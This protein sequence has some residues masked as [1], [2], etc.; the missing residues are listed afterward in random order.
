MLA[1]AV[2]IYNTYPGKPRPVWSGHPSGPHCP[3]PE[4]GK[5]IFHGGFQ[6]RPKPDLRL[7]LTVPITS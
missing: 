7:S 3:M 2:S 4:A 1:V 5:D 6:P